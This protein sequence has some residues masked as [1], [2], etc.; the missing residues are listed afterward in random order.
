MIRTGLCRRATTKPVPFSGWR[1]ASRG[2][3]SATLAVETYGKFVQVQRISE[4]GLAT[5]RDTI[6]TLAETEGLLAHRDAVL[7]RF[8]DGAE[9]ER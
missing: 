3:A 4:E 8:G 7:A 5:I 6:A 1:T 2:H 9:A